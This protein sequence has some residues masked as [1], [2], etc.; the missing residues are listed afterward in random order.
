[1]PIFVPHLDY[2]QEIENALE[3]VIDRSEALL[4]RFPLREEARRSGQ[5]SRYA[6]PAAIVVEPNA[7]L[8]NH[9][10]SS[11]TGEEY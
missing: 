6:K 10:I 11:A 5:A 1:V 9:P 2:V 8:P 3:S 7:N 4:H